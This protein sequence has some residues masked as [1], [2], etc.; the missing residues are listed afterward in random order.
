[1]PPEREGPL[2]QGAESRGLGGAGEDEVGT[3]KG[4]MNVR[5]DS[6]VGANLEPDVL[7]AGSTGVPVSEVAEKRVQ[8]PKTRKGKGTAGVPV[9]QTPVSATPS[10]SRLPLPGVPV[11]PVDLT[12][13]ALMVAGH[14]ASTIAGGNFE[15]ALNDRL[16]IIAEPGSDEVHRDVHHLA[17]KL[18]NRQ[19]VFFRSVEEKESVLTECN[20]IT[21]RGAS[22]T[23]QERAAKGPDTERPYFEPIPEG[24]RKNLV[25]NMV[26]GQYDPEGLLKGAEKHKQSALN[27][28][29]RTL[30]RNGTYLKGD[31][32]RVLQ[33]VRSLLPRFQ[34]QQKARGGVAQQKGQR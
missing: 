2:N 24:V 5:P 20:R 7:D 6:A 34:A 26:N 27:E 29:E 21:G 17:R 3:Q 33:K 18:L 23:D 22:M 11:A 32:S 4:N 1:M 28:I 8:N 16:K 9:S 13:K 12:R 25:S 15:G 30:M 14:G 10:G 19:L 31:S